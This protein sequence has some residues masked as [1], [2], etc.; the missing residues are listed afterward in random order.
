MTVTRLL[1]IVSAAG[2]LAACASTAGSAAPAH[3]GV[4][5]QALVDAGCPPARGST[6][7][8]DRAMTARLTITTRAGKA[9]TKA[10]TDAEG[11]FQV[12]LAPGQYLLHATNTTGSP[13]P[14]A[15][16][17]EFTVTD[18]RYTTVTVQFDSGI[19]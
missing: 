3:S 8:P 7:C 12:P 6:A 16:S 18:G 10:A 2:L 13:V 14:A 9:V 17:I 4:R 15:G 19:R 11:R 5:G 1:V